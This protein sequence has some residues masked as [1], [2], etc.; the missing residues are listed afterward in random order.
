[1]MFCLA[2]FPGTV[3]TAVILFN[4]NLVAMAMESLSSG[5]ILVARNANLKGTLALPKLT[6][7]GIL[8]VTGNS[9]QSIDLPV[10]ATQEMTSM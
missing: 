1:M 10:L 4:S 6:E 7:S 8:L 5:N 3:G 2:A 9:L